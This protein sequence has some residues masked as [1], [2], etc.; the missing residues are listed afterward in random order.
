MKFSTTIELTRETYIPPAELLHRQDHTLNRILYATALDSCGHV[1]FTLLQLSVL[2]DK[3]FCKHR[4]EFS[5]REN[6]DL[7][8]TIMLYQM[9][10]IL[11]RNNAKSGVLPT[12]RDLTGRNRLRLC[13]KS[14]DG[15]WVCRVS[16][17][18]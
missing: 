6:P 12:E 7:D 8:V 3:K 1:Y 10:L 4:M 13:S 5:D 2:V 17:Q 18:C 14:I 11:L 9:I 15:D 16:A